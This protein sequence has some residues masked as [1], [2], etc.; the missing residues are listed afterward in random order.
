MINVLIYCWLYFSTHHT[1]LEY[2]PQR[3]QTKVFTYSV[4]NLTLGFSFPTT[5]HLFTLFLPPGMPCSHLLPSSKYSH[6]S[7]LRRKPL[8][9]QSGLHLQQDAVSAPPTFGICS[10][11]STS[12]LPVP[13]VDPCV[14][15]APSSLL[16]C[17][18]SF[19]VPGRSCLR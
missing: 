18:I 9:A 17:L 19:I 5:V 6:S 14:L 7:R 2:V 8:S 3:K 4:S 13:L 10:F 11:G 16:L 15:G 1:F 12:T